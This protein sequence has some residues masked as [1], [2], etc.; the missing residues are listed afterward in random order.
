MT[1]QDGFF[2]WWE[3]TGDVLC[4]AI[5]EAPSEQLKALCQIAW[6]TGAIRAYR[7]VLDATAKGMIHRQ[8]LETL[9]RVNGNPRIV[10]PEN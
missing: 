6:S 10:D 8:N 3:E 2:A 9:K 5:P 4:C 1:E 7:S